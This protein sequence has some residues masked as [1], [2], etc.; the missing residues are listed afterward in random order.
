M[1]R[2]IAPLLLLTACSAGQGELVS[3]AQLVTRQQ[4]EQVRTPLLFA[5]LES[6][7]TYA[8][9]V[10]AGKNGDVVTWQSG[11]HRALS[12]QQGVVVATRGL[13]DDLMGSDA[14]GVVAML[15]GRAT[16]QEYTRVHSYLDGE[17]QPKFQ[18][19]RC[20][21][22]AATVQNLEI[23]KEI[24]VVTR[25][26]ESCFSPDGGMANTYWVGSDGTVW[27]SRQWISPVL[28]YMETELLVR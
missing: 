13:G 1:I 15:H 4:L 16:G 7:Q 18:S 12:L 19:F 5:Q 8:T 3:P 28:G 11:D 23:V 20:R 22:D 14:D 26:E 27:K 25:I 6:A 2:L 17:Y 9:M 10:P 24:H 21:Q